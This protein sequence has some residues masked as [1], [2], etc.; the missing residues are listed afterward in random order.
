MDALNEAIAMLGIPSSVAIVLVGAFGLLQL[1]G[2][3]LELKGKV[4]PEF[5]KIRKFFLRKKKERQERETLLTD[6]K[7]LLSEAK[8]QLESVNKHY[9]EDNITQRDQ[10]ITTVN[11]NMEWVHERAKVYD[12]SIEGI[13]DTLREAAAALKESTDMTEKLFIENSRDRII[14]FAE[15]V[16]DPIRPVSREEFNRIFKVYSAYEAFLE[17]RH[18][19]NGEVEVAHKIITEAYEEHMKNHTFTENKRNY[20]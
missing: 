2:E 16:S 7:T 12:K 14:D 4:V 18:K 6:V 8:T 5:F 19:T 10:W 1:I 20:D 9:S 15:K 3:I 13:K 17:E 11:T